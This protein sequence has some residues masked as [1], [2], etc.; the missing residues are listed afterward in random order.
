L[1]LKNAYYNIQT[2]NLNQRFEIISSNNNNITT[3]FPHSL[4]LEHVLN[5]ESDEINTEYLESAE[6]D[7]KEPM[8]T[9]PYSQFKE[10]VDK[11]KIMEKNTETIEIE[12]KIQSQVYTNKIKSLEN[13][14]VEVE[15]VNNILFKTSNDTNEILNCVTHDNRRL[16]V[17]SSV[18]GVAAIISVGYIAAPVAVPVIVA[19][20]SILKAGSVLMF[21]KQTLAG[22]IAATTIAATAASKTMT[23]GQ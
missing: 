23:L 13:K 16:K 9:L 19:Q 17:I 15:K 1:I 2:K 4:P 3:S 20:I 18:I 8:V 5:K 22:L 7:L 21:S 11:Y 12:H 10:I 14:I 6:H